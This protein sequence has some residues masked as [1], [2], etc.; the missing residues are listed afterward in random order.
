MTDM[1]QEAYIRM[2]FATPLPH[3]SRWIEGAE[4]LSEFHV[5]P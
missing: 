1:S 3:S 2:K 5:E 4:S